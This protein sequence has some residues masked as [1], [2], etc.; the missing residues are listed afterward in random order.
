MSLICCKLYSDYG[1]LYVRTLGT[2]EW[3]KLPQYLDPEFFDL[4]NV[5]SPTFKPGMLSVIH[6]NER[7]AFV[8]GRL[9]KPLYLWRST[10]K[11]AEL[12]NIRVKEYLLGH[13]RLLGLVM[14][15]VE[16][17]AVCKTPPAGELLETVASGE[18][19]LMYMDNVPTSTP[20]PSSWTTA[21]AEFSD[22]WKH[23]HQEIRLTFDRS[24]RFKDPWWPTEYTP[25]PQERIAGTKHWIWHAFLAFLCGFEWCYATWEEY[26]LARWMSLNYVIA[27][28]LPNPLVEFERMGD[29]WIL[30]KP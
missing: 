21:V 18:G 2:E 6:Q 11:F 22:R 19:E 1:T 9:E 3:T 29:G 5:I 17:L 7:A 20:V 10:F 16:L 30:I 26:E 25:P 15:R 8:D 28:K 14:T 13:S 27:A 4:H 24:I 12:Y 23:G